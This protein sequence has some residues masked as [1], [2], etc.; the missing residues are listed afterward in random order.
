MFMM[1]IIYQ[2]TK[3]YRKVSNQRNFIMFKRMV[4]RVMG[5]SDT[6]PT[7]G[8]GRPPTPPPNPA[9]GVQATGSR[10]NSPTTTPVRIDLSLDI[11]LG[12]GRGWPA[13]ASFVVFHNAL[14]VLVVGTE[15]G[16]IYVFGE[17]FQ[18]MKANLLPGYP[19]V[20]SITELNEGQILVSFSNNALLVMD[21][22]DLNV[23]SSLAA[24]WLRA[25]YISSIRHDE[26]SDKR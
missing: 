8:A 1:T 5:K 20:A 25:G 15:L 18:F 13:Y 26:K 6:V 4:Q 14:G 21:V 22:P 3:L 19:A 23:I 7:A 11:D 17:G 10:A 16:S 9:E 2:L 12:G 24:S